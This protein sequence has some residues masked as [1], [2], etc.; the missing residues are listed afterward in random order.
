MGSESLTYLSSVVSASQD[1][2][3]MKLSIFEIN[4]VPV[5]T[6]PDEALNLHREKI[7]ILPRVD[8]HSGNI[9]RHAKTII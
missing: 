9:D 7:R 1:Y 5:F 8:I 3:Q 4:N 2:G 6:E